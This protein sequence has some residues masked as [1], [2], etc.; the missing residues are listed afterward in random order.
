MPN[1]TQ[2][3]LACPLPAPTASLCSLTLQ[4]F[5]SREEH[6]QKWLVTCPGWG[7]IP[8]LLPRLMYPGPRSARLSSKGIPQKK[9]K[10][11]R[12]ASL[13]FYY[14]V[15]S[16][17]ITSSWC[18]GKTEVYFSGNVERHAYIHS[19]VVYKV[20]SGVRLPECRSQVNHLY[21]RFNTLFS[22]NRDNNRSSTIRLL[23]RSKTIMD[24]KHSAQRSAWSKC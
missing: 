14:N 16:P 18:L 6:G 22:F 3:P 10:Q 19:T 5:S 11:K 4:N 12:N 21:I 24:T 15:I 1:P 7:F 20:A 9:K 23:G 8:M 13:N 17:Q 2:H